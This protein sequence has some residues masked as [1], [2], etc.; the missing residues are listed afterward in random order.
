ME[1][2]TPEQ[3]AILDLLEKVTALQAQ[4]RVLTGIVNA[5]M[6]RK[7]EPMLAVPRRL[8]ANPDLVRMDRGRIART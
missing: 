6:G 2:M 8:T 7:Q 3:A 5:Q 4:V 1:D